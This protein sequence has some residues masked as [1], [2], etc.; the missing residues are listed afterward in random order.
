MRPQGLTWINMDYYGLNAIAKRMGV[1]SPQ[2][3]NWWILHF[4]FPVYK[5]RRPGP[6]RTN[7][8]ARR[9]TYTND[10]MILVWQLAR[11]N[12]E[13]QERLARKE[14]SVR[15]KAVGRVRPDAGP[16]EP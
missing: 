7:Q 6:L 1:G 5:R 13:R 16:P 14:A 4:G 2:T 15:T 10:E 9:L 12:T 3:I 11:A 8:D